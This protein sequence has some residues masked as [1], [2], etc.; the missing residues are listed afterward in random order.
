MPSPRA[1]S[2]PRTL[3]LGP[4]QRALYFASPYVTPPKYIV[5]LLSDAQTPPQ[6]GTFDR[7]LA[8]HDVDD[9]APRHRKA[10]L[11][12][13]SFSLRAYF[14]R[15]TAGAR[16]GADA[17]PHSPIRPPQSP[18]HTKAE[19]KEY[20]EKVYNVKV[21]RVTTSITLGAFIAVGHCALPSAPSPPRAPRAPFRPQESASASPGGV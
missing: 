15:A 14:F 4:R 5:Y 18:K 2:R 12:P 11:Q 21:A 6:H 16:R 7:L 10:S 20:L 13:L 3:A 8:Y 17:P 19:I 1:T 9:G